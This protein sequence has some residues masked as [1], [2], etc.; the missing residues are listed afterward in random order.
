MKNLVKAVRI[1]Q[2]SEI[3]DLLALTLHFHLKQFQLYL[4]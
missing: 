3:D 2:T 1:Y 4:E